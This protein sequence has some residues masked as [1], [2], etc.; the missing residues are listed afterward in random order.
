MHVTIGYDKASTPACLHGQH[1]SLLK[2]HLLSLLM[3]QPKC[4]EVNACTV[5]TQLNQE[6]PCNLAVHAAQAQKAQ[7]LHDER[8][9]M[10]KTLAEND[11]NIKAKKKAAKQQVSAV[12]QWLC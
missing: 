12:H 8:I 7:R 3:S 11:A 1:V 6:L 9:A 4:S 5:L 2:P 10:A